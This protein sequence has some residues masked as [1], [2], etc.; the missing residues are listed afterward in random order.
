MDGLK[1]KVKSL[2]IY[3]PTKKPQIWEP[4]L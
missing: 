3:N 2:Q 1:P 4:I